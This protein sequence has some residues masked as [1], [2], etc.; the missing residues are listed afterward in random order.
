MTTA[1]YEARGTVSI[2]GNFGI[3]GFGFL[4]FFFFFFFWKTAEPNKLDGNKM[5]MENN[6]IF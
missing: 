1:A 2:F 3:L 4:S 5:I 6:N